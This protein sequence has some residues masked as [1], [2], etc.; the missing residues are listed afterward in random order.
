MIALMIRVPYVKGDA[1]GT[2]DI[3][4]VVELLT[5]SALRGNVTAAHNLGVRYAVGEAWFTP[6]PHP[7]P[8]PDTRNLVVGS[9]GS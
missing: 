6:S 3:E 9:V 2:V 7:P 8:W 1:D 4:L 5:K